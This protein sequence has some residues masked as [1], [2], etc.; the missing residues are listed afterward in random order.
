MD[1]VRAVG[2]GSSAEG[3]SSVVFVIADLAAL[4]GSAGGFAFAFDFFFGGFFTIFSVLPRIV[5]RPASAGQR[6]RPRRAP[7]KI[8]E[9]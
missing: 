5:R 2:F 3:S 9:N 7:Y 6:E 8:Q 4:A 1:V